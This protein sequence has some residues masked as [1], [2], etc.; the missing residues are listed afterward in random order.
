MGAWG[1]GNF[2]NDTAL[3]W[4]YAFDSEGAEAVR[5]AVEAALRPGY[6][7]ADVACTAL[8]ACEVVA[9]SAGAGLADDA[10]GDV[11]DSLARHGA[12]V[13]QADLAAACQRIVILAGSETS[14]LHELWDD[15]APEDREGFR[16]ALTGL[17]KRLPQVAPAPVP[18]PA[19]PAK[20]GPSLTYGLKLPVTPSSL[21]EWVLAAFEVL[22]HRAGAPDGLQDGADYGD[23]GLEGM[24]AFMQQHLV[25]L[26]RLEAHLGLP[27]RPRDAV[28]PF[29]DHSAGG[30]RAY[31]MWIAGRFMDI[32]AQLN[33]WRDE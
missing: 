4:V 3:D 16:A 26:E 33:G 15:A 30:L 24:A 20:P 23:E 2:Q 29:D 17:Q 7:D 1:S 14:E 6:L 5:A 10:P 13:R 25:R 27:V 22:E 11:L 18:D 21:M 28:V 8:A 19:K 9:A 12:D 31:E 32:E